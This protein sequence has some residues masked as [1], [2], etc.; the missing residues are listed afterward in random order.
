MNGSR[1]A[2]Q[3]EMHDW[4]KGLLALRRA[5]DALQT[6][7]QQVLQAGTDTMTYV[8]GRNLRWGCASGDGEGRV[9]V[10]VNKGN[11]VETLD[12]P[13]SHTAIAECHKTSALWGA[14]GMVKVNGDILHVVVSPGSVEIMSVN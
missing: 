4:V 5:H 1:T 9:L 2:A 10:V 11:N 3:K 14:E 7:E 13:M 8:R 6:G 12:L